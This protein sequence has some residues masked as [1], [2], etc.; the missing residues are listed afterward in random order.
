M[1][2]YKIVNKIN[3][4]ISHIPFIEQ[5]KY[6]GFSFVLIGGSSYKSS[7]FNKFDHHKNFYNKLN[8]DTKL[9]NINFQKNLSTITTTFAFDRPT[10]ILNHNLFANENYS[11][12]YIASK[13][14]LTIKN[15]ALFIKKLLDHNN[16]KPPYV[17]IVFSE[18]GYD[19]LCFSKYFE[20]LIKQ[21]Y[22]IDTPFID[23]FM[24]EYE[25][26]RGNI[27]WLNGV[28]KG[29]FAW[30]QKKISFDDITLQ[31]IDAYNFDI[32]TLN[33]ISKLKLTDFP[34]TIPSFVLLSPYEVN[35][36][37][38]L[39]QNKTKIDI[40]NKQ[41]HQLKC[42]NRNINTFWIDAPHQM[43]RTKSKFLVEFIKLHLNVL[44]LA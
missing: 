39:E 35:E 40:L 14:D 17:F 2:K 8:P 34:K 25:K 30:D 26:F 21:I 20:S 11:H 15:N 10:D 3:N 22:F 41:F 12:I 32:K 29:K 42:I 1:N 23:N 31:Q 13:E 9:P 16:I 27:N 33:V 4:M 6:N 38:K 43:E 24:V 37:G 7:M 18:G 19:V 28:L 5:G 36:K 44:N